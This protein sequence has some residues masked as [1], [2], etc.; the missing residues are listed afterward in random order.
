MILRRWHATIR[1]EDEKAY[2]DYIM[3]TGASAYRETQ[4]NLGF[5]VLSRDLGQGVTEVVTLSG[6]QDIAAIKAFAG[7]DYEQSKYYADDDR[8]LLTKTDRVEHYDVAISDIQLPAS[9]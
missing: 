2:V 6:W 1:S 8:F 3:A 9:P 7:D 5:Q 4:G